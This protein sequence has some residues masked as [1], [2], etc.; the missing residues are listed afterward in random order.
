MTKREARN[1][2]TYLGNSRVQ[3][4]EKTVA[5]AAMVKRGTLFYSIKNIIRGAAFT[6]LLATTL[7]T[8]AAPS[9]TIEK[10]VQ[11]WPWNNKVDIAYN[12]VDGQDVKKDVYYR[13]EFTVVVDG[14]T[15]IIDGVTDIGASAA[16]G[17]HTVTWNAPK[18]LEATNC[19][20][21]ATIHRSE[22]PS[23]DDYLVI[24]LLDGTVAF[25]GLYSSLAL[26]LDRYTNNVYKTDKMVLRRVPAGGTY[27][28]MLESDNRTIALWKTDRDFYMGIFMVTQSQ[29]MKLGYEVN[30]AKEQ[31][32]VP[33]NLAIYR[34][35]NNVLF[36]DVRGSH[37][38][39]TNALPQV[40]APNEG[41]FF[42]RLNFL[43]G[44]RFAFDLPTEVMFEM[45]E[46]AGT[47]TKYFWGDEM[48]ESYVVC[49]E[50]SGGLPAQVGSRKYNDWGFFDM[51]GNLYEFV[52]DD[53]SQDT[54]KRSN[55]WI[56][57]YSPDSATLSRPLRLRGGA[58]FDVTKTHAHFGSNSRY[59]VSRTSKGSV[60]FRASW[61]VH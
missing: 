42:Q 55:P 39:T 24:N 53:S 18:V 12:V 26:S 5:L 21:F 30:P 40:S 29:F 6:A 48:D 33:G 27:P 28:S 47:T 34:P 58:S 51:S 7:E 50:N 11:R 54:E 45:C 31:T 25:E 41:T 37:D 2:K 23:G 4:D 43:T 36:T 20:M 60:G 46:R 32:D 16:T 17:R 8:I 56:P 49:S 44:N 13:L 1:R 38:E 59:S 35:V 9:V 52:L 10:V 22:V 19:E 57:A 15:N 3:S 14:V 61:I